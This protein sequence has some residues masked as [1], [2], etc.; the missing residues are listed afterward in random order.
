MQKQHRQASQHQHSPK[1]TR[2]RQPL[3]RLIF[4][5]KQYITLVCDYWVFEDLQG[6]LHDWSTLNKLHFIA[7]LVF[8]LDSGSIR[9]Q[10]RQC[11]YEVSCDCRSATIPDVPATAFTTYSNR[12]AFF[13]FTTLLNKGFNPICQ[14]RICLPRFLLGDID[15]VL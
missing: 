6:K 7:Q 15:F 5:I 10:W 2:Q 14:M 8:D 1:T 11:D 12:Y 4:Q 13:I 3:D 9:P